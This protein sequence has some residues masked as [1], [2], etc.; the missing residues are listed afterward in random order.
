MCCSFG[1]LT[2]EKQPIGLL[3]KINNSK[4]AEYYH[5]KVDTLTD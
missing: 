1:A 5:E 2:D 3:D 4:A